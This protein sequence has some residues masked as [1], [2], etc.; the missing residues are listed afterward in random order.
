[1]AEK[2]KKRRLT[3]K[4][5]KLILAGILAVVLIVLIVANKE[6]MPVDLVVTSVNM[7]RA[8]V[9]GITFLMGAA[10]GFLLGSYLVARRRK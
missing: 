8:M 1:M 2:P 6:S 9:L 10:A 3:M 4:R 5:V 7:P